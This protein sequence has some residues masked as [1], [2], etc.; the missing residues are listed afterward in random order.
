MTDGV[1]TGGAKACASC[2]TGRVVLTAARCP[3]FGWRYTRGTPFASFSP[4]VDGYVR[5]RQHRL[6]DVWFRQ[7]IVECGPV[8]VPNRHEQ[9]RDDGTNDDASRSEQDDPTE[10]GKQYHEVGHLRVASDQPWA[11]EAVDRA[12]DSCAPSTESDGFG[13]PTNQRQIG[14]DGHANQSRAESRNDRKDGHD[15]AP[16]RGPVYSDHG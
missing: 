12:D 2:R 14:D 8:E 7:Y 4:R 16:Y 1:A 5:S 11:K 9:G 10:R 3:R 6:C 15:R 13:V